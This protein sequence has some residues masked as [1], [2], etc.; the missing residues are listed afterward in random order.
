MK[1]YRMD[2]ERTGADALGIEAGEWLL[3]L[4]E[5]EQ[6][7]REGFLD[8]ITRSPRHLAM[9]LETFEAY[10]LLGTM[11][12]SRAVSV[13]RL[14]RNLDTDVIRMRADSVAAATRPSWSFR[15]GRAVSAA[16][17]ITALIV[18]ALL[19]VQHSG[20]NGY[21]TAV[22]EQ[23]ICKLADGSFVYLNTDSR[24]TVKFSDSERTVQLERGE[25]LFSVERDSSRPFVVSTPDAR[26]RVLGT[27]FNVRRRDNQTDVAVLDGLVQVTPLSDNVSSEATVAEPL[28]PGEE[29]YVGTST[30]ARKANANVQSVVAWRARRLAFTEASLAEVAG[31]FNRYNEKKVRID[32]SVPASKRLTGIFDADRPSA[33]VMYAMKDESLVVEPKE[34]EWI[35]KAR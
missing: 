11:D 33:L 32:G 10:R 12:P 19:W 5:D 20:S 25:A 17:A 6:A 28:R 13:E 8:W 4:Q 7:H 29:A 27:Q 21:T 35:I 2:T 26:I 3:R 34:G 16:A 1:I 18:G 23:R 24:I 9:F 15:K 14:V 22:G 31:E 30:V